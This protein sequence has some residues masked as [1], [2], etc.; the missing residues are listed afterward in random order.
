MIE[1]L[2]IPDF[3]QLLPS[4]ANELEDNIFWTYFLLLKNGYNSGILSLLPTFWYLLQDPLVPF[5]SSNSINILSSYFFEETM[6]AKRL[7][8]EFKEHRMRRLHDS[9]ATPE[10]K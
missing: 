2:E 10:G 3:L 9:K 5:F 4:V 7:N 8:V 6:F 1:N